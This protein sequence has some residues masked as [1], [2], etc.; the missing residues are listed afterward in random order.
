MAETINSSAHVC[1]MQL[2]ISEHMLGRL[3]QNA[4]KRVDFLYKDTVE[5]TGVRKT[6]V[7]GKEEESSRQ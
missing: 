5:R 2:P 6:K 4:T 7:T 1:L 3:W